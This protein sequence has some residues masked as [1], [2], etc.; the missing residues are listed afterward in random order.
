MDVI[1]VFEVGDTVSVKDE[2]WERHKEVVP[3]VRSSSPL[4]GEIESVV[5]LKDRLVYRI[6]GYLWHWSAEELEVKDG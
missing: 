2:I 6:K 1:I 3:S 5:E 4:S